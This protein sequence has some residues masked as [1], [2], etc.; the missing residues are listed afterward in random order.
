MALP[1][2]FYI[3]ILLLL[4]DNFGFVDVVGVSLIVGIGA[5]TMYQ[6]YKGHTSVPAKPNDTL[7]NFLLSRN[8]SM[9]ATPMAKKSPSLTEYY[10]QKLSIIEMA[11]KSPS[12]PS[13]EMKNTSIPSVL[14][15]H[16]HQKIQIYQLLLPLIPKQNW[17]N[18]WIVSQK[19]ATRHML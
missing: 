19:F 6:I 18:Y 15:F 3:Y 14:M 9:Q 13:I 12:S 2:S 1:W 16:C 5:T 7:T 10:N 17:Q 8:S 11:K 4:F